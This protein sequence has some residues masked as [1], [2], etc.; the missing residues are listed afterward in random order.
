M[1]KRVLIIGIDGCTWNILQP[2][3]ESDFMPNFAKLIEQGNSF[4]LQSTIPPV[5]APAW[6]SFLTGKKVSKHRIYDFINYIPESRDIILNNSRTIRTQTIWT[7]L[8]D[9]G[10][11]VGCIN[12]PM[13]FPVYDVN[14]FMI[15]GFDTPGTESSFIFPPDEKD[16]FLDN[17]PNYEFE[18]VDTN[19]DLENF[20]RNLQFIEKL[21]KLRT[22]VSIDFYKR[23]KPDVLMA[24]FQNLDALQH[25]LYGLLTGKTGVFSQIHVDKVKEL[26]QTLDTH[27]GRILQI[28]DMDSMKIVLSDHGFTN[29]EGTAFPNRILIDNGYLKVNRSFIKNQKTH[30]HR[31][32][33]KV[34]DKLPMS[35]KRAYRFVK[36][37]S[38]VI[39][40]GHNVRASTFNISN[41]DWENTLA[42]TAMGSLCGFI[43]INKDNLINNSYENLT[44][45]IIRLFCSQ[46]DENGDNLFLEVNRTENFYGS[47]QDNEPDIVIFPKKGVTISLETHGRHYFERN[48]QITRGTHDPNGILVIS[49]EGI[50]RVKND[51]VP[52]IYDIVPTLLYTLDISIPASVDGE[53]I[54]ELFED[55]KEAQY[56][57]DSELNKLETDGVYLSDEKEVV[58]SRL[59]KLGYF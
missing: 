19:I 42:F 5:T 33:D 31:N 1:I 13:T 4:T 20:D 55:R 10:F 48:K 30:I 21:I 6:T 40:T 36:K 8:S 17:Y 25:A 16:Y 54:Y 9:A 51:I 14:G 26:Y 45:E 12:A 50:K 28:F 27:L 39:L 7:L 32:I 15:S 49:G 2:L 41:V 24:H 52:R 43:Y 11:K 18:T 34:Y 47:M 23:Y 58:L 44:D 59:K 35:V 37:S 3:I 57:S 53:V 46:R 56:H 38:S 22:E 29:L